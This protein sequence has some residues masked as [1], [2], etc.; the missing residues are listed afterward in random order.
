MP[1]LLWILLPLALAA[2][3]DLR[4]Q[5]QE[6]AAPAPET[7]AA[8]YDDRDCNLHTPLQ[9]G[10][11]GSPGNLITSPRNPNGDSELS[12]LM[13]RFVDDLREARPKLERG[14]RVPALF[15]AHR[16]MRCAW[17]TRPEERDESYDRMALTYLHLVRA[18]DRAPGKDTYNGILGGCIACHTETCKGPLDLIDGMIWR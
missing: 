17:H 9:P 12:A 6:P 15:D 2:A 1:R 10:I 16:R 5:P 14:E 11:P 4:E 7:F 18:Y 8:G 13:R 3:C